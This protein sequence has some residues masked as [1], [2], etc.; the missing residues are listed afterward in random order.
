M[1]DEKP[2]DAVRE[3]VREGY[4]GIAR[5]TGQCCGGATARA[6]AVAR[7]VG[8]SEADVQAVPAGANLGL[9]CGN[10]LSLANV[11]PGEPVVDLG[12]GAGFDALLAAQVV[13][14]TGRVVGIDMTPEMLAR[15]EVNADRAGLQNVEFRRGYIEALPV[16]DASVDVIISNCVI[17]L[18]PEKPAVLAQS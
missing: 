5:N 6:D 1:T 18:S 7:R 9:G 8:Y 14:P 11:Q 4:A 12:S 2:R 15:A 10:P 17:N 13:G 16:D 3:M